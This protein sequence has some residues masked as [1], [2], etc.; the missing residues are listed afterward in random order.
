MITGFLRKESERSLK[1]IGFH[2]RNQKK[3]NIH[4]AYQA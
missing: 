2:H 3:N 1:N 4:G